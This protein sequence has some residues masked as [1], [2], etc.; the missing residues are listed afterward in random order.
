MKRIL[1]FSIFIT[2]LGCTSLKQEPLTLTN[3]MNKQNFTVEKPENW[4][5]MNIHGEINFTPLSMNQFR[6][7]TSISQIHLKDTADFH[8]YVLQRIAQDKNSFNML[9]QNVSLENSDLG[10]IY[11]YNYEYKW[12][13]A[14]T[15]KNKKVIGTNIYKTYYVYFQ[16]EG[17]YYVFNYFSSKELYSKYFA[18][19]IG[20]LSSINF[21]EKDVIPSV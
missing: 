6:N 16:N 2:V 19:A 11:I 13:F 20:I 3:W 5:T 9:S 7:H 10:E 1:L 17:N 14:H 15:E 18:D 21:K 8:T 4:K 12:K